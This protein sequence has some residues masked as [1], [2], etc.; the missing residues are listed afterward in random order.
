MIGTSFYAFRTTSRICTTL[1][2]L[3][4]GG[5][6]LQSPIKLTAAMLKEPMQRK[7]EELTGVL[8]QLRRETLLSAYQYN[9][10]NVSYLVNKQDELLL[11]SDPN[12][13]P[14]TALCSALLRRQH[15]ELGITPTWRLLALS[16]LYRRGYLF[17]I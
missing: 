1:L 9:P 8:V 15:T 4:T 3:I 2:S 11:S 7:R 13:T 10:G 12:A 17:F 6:W 5:T 16:R 14:Q